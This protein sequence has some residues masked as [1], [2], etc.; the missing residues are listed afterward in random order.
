MPTLADLLA[1]NVF[2]LDDWNYEGEEEED[3]SAVNKASI[4]KVGYT[5]YF[6][7]VATGLC[8]FVVQ[9][10]FAC[11]NAACMKMGLVRIEVF[12]FKDC[13]STCV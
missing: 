1:V 11:Y 6:T 9:H 5:R 8:M 4:T 13:N 12:S 10:I 3:S 2:E 7:T